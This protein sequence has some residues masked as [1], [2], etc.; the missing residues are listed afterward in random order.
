M[1]RILSK[2]GAYT[3]HIAA[4]SE[5]ARGADRYKLQGYY[6]RWVEGKYILG[7][8][9]FIDLLNPCAIFSKSVQ[10]D[11]IDILGALTC[12]LKT[13]TETDKL[14]KKTLEQWPT[15]A[16]TQ[17]KCTVEDG[18]NVYQCKSSK[19]LLWLNP[20]TKLIMLSTALGLWNA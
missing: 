8:A 2:Y 5:D 9:V 3:S 20:S 18:A 6:K 11:E 12:L 19:S 7:C 13:I 17:K 14:G 1:K 4:L 16:A 15:Y 10:S